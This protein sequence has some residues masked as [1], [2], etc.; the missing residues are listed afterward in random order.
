[1]LSRF[2]SSIA[3]TEFSFS[4]VGAS[5]CFVVGTS[6][7]NCLDSADVLA[8]KLDDRLAPLVQ[9]AEQI[10]GVED[11]RVDLL[12]ALRQDRR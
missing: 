8:S 2:F 1:M 10:V 12:A 9:H 11:Q 7:D 4:S 3:V 6:P 5:F